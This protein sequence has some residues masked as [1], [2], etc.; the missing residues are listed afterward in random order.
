M[1]V[2]FICL[3][4]YVKAEPTEVEQP[5]KIDSFVLNSNENER[6]N[7]TL[8]TSAAMEISFEYRIAIITDISQNGAEVA[9][10]RGQTGEDTIID[11]DMSGINTYDNY[12][13]KIT[14][15]YY[16]EDQKYIANSYS[17]IFEY[18]Q[19]SYAEDLSGRDLTVDALA[20]VLKINWSRYDSYSADSVLVAIDVDGERVVEDVIPAGDGGYDY[21]YDEN[22]KQITVQ[23]KQVIDG[24]LSNGLTDTIDVV[25]ATDTK[26]FYIT[27]PEANKQYD[28]IWNIHYFNGEAT[29]LNYKTDSNSGEYEFNGNGSFLIEMND[30]NQKLFISYM[31][32][33]N[34]LWEYDFITT[35]VEYAP[36][37][38]LLEEY[39]GATIDGGSVTIVGK[40][41]DTNATIKVNGAEVSVDDKG[42]FRKTVE[43]VAGKNIID[44][45][46]TSIIGKSSRTSVTV[47]KAGTDEGIKETSFISKYSTLIVSLSASVIL[48]VILCVIVKKGGKKK[49]EKEA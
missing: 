22:T 19:E 21:Y 5:L 1:C 30:D 24:K 37:I 20:R 35:I 44:I 27:A 48:L 36:T 46:A 7:A 47:Y 45:E 16:V 11:I 29:K 41:D 17:Q 33:K 40:V 10:G 26:D 18:T 8:K 25:K 9:H 38:Q 2:I 6:I 3:P 28:A 49:N 12:R 14:V 32:A 4:M 23:L 13:F 15:T 42:T 39:N 34:V 43:L 31:D